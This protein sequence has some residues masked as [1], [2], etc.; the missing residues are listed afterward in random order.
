MTGKG[1]MDF[2]VGDK[3]TGEFF[4]SSITGYGCYLNHL[5]TK[6]IGYF[7]D[8][9]CNKHGKKIYPDGTVYLGEFLKDTEHGK[10][11]LTLKN[12]V[13]LKGV[14]TNGKLT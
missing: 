4:N 3:Y 5:G 12:G 10:G 7:N 8:G 13:Q 6:L 9:V 1:F 11:V 14:W 2:Y